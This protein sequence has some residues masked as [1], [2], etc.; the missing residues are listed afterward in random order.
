MLV[1]IMFVQT[2]CWPKLCYAVLEVIFYDVSDPF[3]T[4]WE[5]TALMSIKCN[6]W[7]SCNITFTISR[8]Q[9]KETDKYVFPVGFRNKSWNLLGGGGLIWLGSGSFYHL[10]QLSTKQ[11]LGITSLKH[12][13][14]DR[15]VTLSALR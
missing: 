1:N 10:G 14:V 11:P 8:S 9:L 12:T 7:E 15:V 4:V 2:Y 13:L 5:V 3:H 6:S